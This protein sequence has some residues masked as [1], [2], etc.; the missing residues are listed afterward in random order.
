[1]TTRSLAAALLLVVALALAAC[2]GSDTSIS[3]DGLQIEGGED[4]LTVNVDGQTLEVQNENAKVP[5][6]FPAAIPLPDGDPQTAMKAS[7]DGQP[8]WTLTYPGDAAAYDSYVSKIV[9][10][11]GQES[12]FSMDQEGLKSSTYAIDGNDVSV[13]LID[14]VGLSIVVQPQK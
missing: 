5:D 10:E 13:Q 9:N 6:D 3:V 12:T 4:G 7:T 14:G 1:M 2:G 11:T 8:I